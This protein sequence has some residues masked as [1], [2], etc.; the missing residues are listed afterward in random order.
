MF[1]V[2]E[3]EKLREEFLQILFCKG[4]QEAM[5][6]IHKLNDLSFSSCCSKELVLQLKELIVDLILELRIFRIKRIKSI[7]HV[8]AA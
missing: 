8:N 6:F 3:M 7:T 2:G 4:E 1:I 5:S